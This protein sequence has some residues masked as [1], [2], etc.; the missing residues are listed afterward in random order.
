MVE[1][2]ERIYR[3]TYDVQKSLQDLRDLEKQLKSVEKARKSSGKKGSERVKRMLAGELSVRKKLDDAVSKYR[4][5]VKGSERDAVRAGKNIERIIKADERATLRLAKAS[6]MAGRAALR[7]RK[8]FKGA[9]LGIGSGRGGMGAMIRQVTAT[10][11]ALVSLYKVIQ[12]IGEAKDRFLRFDELTTAAMTMTHAGE[13]AFEH[14]SR[15]AERYRDAIR[16]AANE[17]KTS[18]VAMSDSALFWAKAGQTNTDTITELSKVGTMFARANRDAANNVLDQARA[19]DILSDA[20]QLFRKDTSTTIKAAAAA[21]ELSD[22]LTAAANS[23][24]IVVE[25]LFNYSKKVAGLFKAGEVADD[26][27]MA[28]AASLASAGLKEESGVHVRR[29][30]TRLAQGNVQKLLKG[31][32][33]DVADEAGEIRSF[34]NIF[35]ELQGVLKTQ[36]PLERISFLKD[37][38]GQRAI[39]TAA[40]LAGLNEEGVPGATSIQAILGKIGEAEGIARR[41]QEQ[42]LKTTGGRVQ[43]LTSTWGNALDRVL[44]DSG[45]IQKILSGIEDISPE[46]LFG[47]METSVI[48]ALESF[49]ITMRD[50]VIPGVR[51]AGESIS[52]WLSPAMSVLSG[53]LG[54]TTSNAEGL[55]DTITTIVKLWV[56]WKIGLLA[57][58][59]LR[60][61]DWFVQFAMKAKAAA[62]ATKTIGTATATSVAVSKTAIGTLPAAFSAAGIG[63]AAAIAAWGL[64]DLIVGPIRDAEKRISKFRAKHGEGFERLKVGQEDYKTLGGRIRDAERAHK[65]TITS[66]DPRAMQNPAVMARIEK[67]YADIRRLKDLQSRGVAEEFG[68]GQRTTTG[69]GLYTGG[70]SDIGAPV[71]DESF[72]FE[73]Q[74][75]NKLWMEWRDASRN[76]DADLRQ[77]AQMAYEDALNEKLNLYQGERAAIEQERDATYE[78][79]ITAASDERDALH[80]QLGNIADRFKENAEKI[81]DFTSDLDEIAGVMS[82]GRQLE[83]AADVAAKR[84]QQRR[85]A[86]RGGGKSKPLNPFA[87]PLL[88][89]LDQ[90]GN[91]IINLALQKGNAA[92][93]FRKSPE[94][95]ASLERGVSANKQIVNIHYGDATISITAKTDAKPEDIARVVKDE[96]WKI[97]QRQLRDSE[98]R[99]GMIAP[100]EI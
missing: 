12:K 43:A 24:N 41:N 93:Y 56:K 52:E 6:E 48:P 35:G 70:K 69:L 3:V 47:W 59:G 26:E 22:K 40:A 58:R 34:G 84:K 30:L 91:R 73:T 63:I 64:Y 21:T 10:T 27:I 28:V 62:V 66:L 32:G 77:T 38:F 82:E 5:N 9:I 76:D 79:F 87:T 67:G 100:A 7:S 54:S 61:A 18:A 45:V 86:F 72:G 95:R 57:I 2:K 36:K 14:G 20:L 98:Q 17:V 11:L 8:Q 33:I 42:S 4:K 90:E 85:G 89:G 65:K 97:G 80:E 16:E 83:R 49:G 23:S 92:E 51:M 37:L 81:G 46:E 44:E 19:N 13:K 53:L 94:A 78:K 75:L 68:V 55:A 74:G 50:T 88:T 39:S 96:A 25:Q 31:V 29:I 1:I 99:L 15:G 71:P 60:M